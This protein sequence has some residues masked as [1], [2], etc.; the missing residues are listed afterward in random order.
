MC[1]F[2]H[3]SNLSSAGQSGHGAGIAGDEDG[4]VSTIEPNGTVYAH[5]PARG[6]AVLE[7]PQNAGLRYLDNGVALL[8]VARVGNGRPLCTIFE[9]AY[10]KRLTIS[11]RV[12]SVCG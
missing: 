7:R 5:Q 3:E 2:L 1:S 9:L 11:Q 12:Y 4:P 8:T 6:D 10:G